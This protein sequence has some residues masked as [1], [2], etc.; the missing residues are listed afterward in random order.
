MSIG[1]V[2]IKVV[3]LLQISAGF[4]TIYACQCPSVPEPSTV[5]GFSV[6]EHFVDCTAWSPQEARYFLDATPMT[7]LEN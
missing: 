1:P 7:S 2:M 6:F 4:F 5:G 3:Y